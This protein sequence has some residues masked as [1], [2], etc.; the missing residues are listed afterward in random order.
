MARSLRPGVCGYAYKS[1]SFSHVL[2]DLFICITLSCVYT[3]RRIFFYFSCYFFVTI[4]TKD[5]IY[6][7]K[8]PQIFDGS[9]KAS[10][11]YRNKAT[12]SAV[13]NWNACLFEGRQQREKR[14][15]NL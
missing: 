2:V 9:G 11:I 6:V 4:D 5:V 12:R 7:D 14:Q 10:S 13:A 15:L 3:S 8:H 1:L